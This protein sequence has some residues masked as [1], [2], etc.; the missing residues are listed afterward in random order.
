MVACAAAEAIGMTAAAGAARSATALT[1]HGVT[2]RHRLGTSGHRPGRPGRGD[3]PGLAPGP[4]TRHDPRPDRAPALG[5][6]DG[7]GGRPRLVRRVPARRAR[8]RRGRWS[9]TATP[10]APGSRRPRWRDG[11]PARRRTGVDPEAPGPSPLAVGH[12]QHRGVDRRDAGHLPRRHHRPGELAVV[13]VVPT[14]AVTGLVAGSAL[15]VVSGSFLDS[16]D[17]PAWHHRVVLADP[18][19]PPGPEPGRRRGRRSGRAG[20]DG[21][22]HRPGLPLPGR[23]SVVAPRPT[24]RAAR[25][26]GP[27]DLVAQP[28]REA[29]GRGAPGRRLAAGGGLGAPG[30]RPRLV[31]GPRGVRGAASGRW[32]RAGTRWSC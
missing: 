29:D 21:C 1:D 11:R 10:R 27:E 20:R 32:G 9:A 18:V 13:V 19:L 4:G 16:L 5:P 15:G 6:R 24:R 14:G 30:G 22:A 28:G 8:R 26:S 3:C 23:G 7:P 25:A 2:P 12:R 31:R 17:G